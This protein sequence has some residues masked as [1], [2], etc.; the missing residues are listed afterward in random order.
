[1]KYCEQCGAQ[2]SDSAR[3]CSACGTAAPTVE[4]PKVI[5]CKNCGEQ[6]EERTSFALIVG[7]L[8]LVQK[9][10]VLYVH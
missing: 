8:V 2:L 9:K 10:R 6:L 4:T 3:F 5:I 1:M 7:S